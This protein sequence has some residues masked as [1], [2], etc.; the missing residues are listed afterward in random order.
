[1]STGIYER[2]AARAFRPASVIL[3]LTTSIGGPPARNGLTMFCCEPGVN[4]I[5]D[6]A[7]IEPMGEHKHIIGDAVWIAGEHF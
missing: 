3:T 5:G 1:M 4:E 7:A 2:S 6:H